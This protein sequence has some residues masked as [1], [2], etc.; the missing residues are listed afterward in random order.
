MQFFHKKGLVS[1]V[2]FA[3]LK[4]PLVFFSEEACVGF[5]LF[6]IENSVCFRRHEHENVAHCGDR[7]FFPPLTF[8]F[9]TKEVFFA[10]YV[11]NN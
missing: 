9:I 5:R 10:V 1:P 3:S 11:E 7:Y 4:S 8:H 6:R 2:T